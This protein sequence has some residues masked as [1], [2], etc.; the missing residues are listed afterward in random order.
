MTWS[1]DATSTIAVAV[2]PPVCSDPSARGADKTKQERQTTADGRNA[3]GRGRKEDLRPAHG[4]IES[5]SVVML[6]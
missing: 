6:F 1:S 2:L 3:V 5:S 4:E